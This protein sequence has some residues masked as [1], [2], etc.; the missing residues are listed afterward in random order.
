[1]GLPEFEKQIPSLQVLP[2]RAVARYVYRGSSIDPYSVS[3][4]PG[5]EMTVL[6]TSYDSSW[7][8]IGLPDDH[9]G[10]V[11]SICLAPVDSMLRYRGPPKLSSREPL[12]ESLPRLF[13]ESFQGSLSAKGSLREGLQFEE[14]QSLASQREGHLFSPASQGLELPRLS[15]RHSPPGSK[16]IESRSGSVSPCSAKSL[17]RHGR[18]PARQKRPS[19]SCWA[20][21]QRVCCRR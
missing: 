9:Y 5:Q 16:E 14:P 11:P 12:Q 17:L 4:R 6:E 19:Q 20:F 1:M 15:S 2:G 7:A 18:S 8:L 10:W 13:G 3:L 21:V